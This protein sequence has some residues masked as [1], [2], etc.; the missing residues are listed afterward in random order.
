M[1]HK[2]LSYKNCKGFSFIKNI[3]EKYLWKKELGSGSF[4]VVHE[5]FHIKAK[6]PVAIKVVIK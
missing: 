5:A 3:K 6:T 4:G 1:I 2:V